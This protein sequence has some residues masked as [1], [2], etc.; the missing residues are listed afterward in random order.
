[1]KTTFTDTNNLLRRL[2]IA[3]FCDIHGSI[4]MVMSLITVVV[5]KIQPSTNTAT[6]IE[7]SVSMFPFPCQLT[8]ADRCIGRIYTLSMLSNLSN[9]CTLTLGES[10]GSSG[11]RQD[12]RPLGHNRQRPAHPARCRDILLPVRRGR[13][14]HGQRDLESGDGNSDVNSVGTVEKALRQ[15]V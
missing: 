5:F 3:S 12:R 9:N 4:T 13:D 6:M 11:I 8:V 1:M 2:S 14:S 15:R 10:Q 7:A